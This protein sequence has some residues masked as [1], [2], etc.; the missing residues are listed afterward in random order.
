[1][2]CVCSRRALTLVETIAAIGLLATML[3]SILAA[4]SFESRAI[5]FRKLQL[6][7]VDIIDQQLFEWTSIKGGI[8]VPAAGSFAGRDDL[9]WKTYYVA[10]A[11]PHLIGAEVARVEVSARNSR[12]DRVT[13]FSVDLFVATV[14]PSK[15]I[16]A[17]GP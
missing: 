6:E 9:F 12:G 1:M 4:F 10:S 15:Q 3:V 11:N 7:A 5:D 14:L 2:R 17:E 8:P 13:L 16:D